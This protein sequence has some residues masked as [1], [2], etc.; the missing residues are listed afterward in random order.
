MHHTTAK[1]IA[2]D[3]AEAFL[4]YGWPEGSQAIFATQ[5]EALRR[6]IPQHI[7]AA[8]AQ[9]KAKHKEAVVGVFEEKCGGCHGPLSKTALARLNAETEVSCCEHCGRFIYL[10]GGHNLAP[11]GHPHQLPGGDARR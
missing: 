2:L 7:V 11:S 4:A 5:A 10:A 8:Y 3:R 6:E 9:L 1:L